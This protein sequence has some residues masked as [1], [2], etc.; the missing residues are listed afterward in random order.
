[1]HTLSE[2]DINNIL[3]LIAKAPITGEGAVTVALLQQKLQ[4]LLPVKKQEN[5]PTTTNGG[6]AEAS[7]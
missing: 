6:A 5:E 4:A 1:M 7:K 2:Q 3:A